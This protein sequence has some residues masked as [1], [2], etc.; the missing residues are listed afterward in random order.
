MITLSRT[1]D[2]LE[3]QEEM[4]KAE[5]AEQEEKQGV[6][7]YSETQEQV[8]CVYWAKVTRGTAL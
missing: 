6:V 2:I 1:K 8:C 3:E 5:L 4:Q 7:G